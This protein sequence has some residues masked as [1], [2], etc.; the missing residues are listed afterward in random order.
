MTDKRSI[1]IFHSPDADDA[2][3]FYGMANGS[4]QNAQFN[5]LHE[6]SDIE[7]LNHR[8]L[9]GELEVSAVS[10]HAFAHLKDR[11]AIL[12]SGA[13]LGGIDY[14]PILVALEPLN[15][16]D[17]ETHVFAIPGELTSAALAFRMYLKENSVKAELVNINFDKVQEAIRDGAVEAGI[18]IHEGQL[19]HR[20]QGFV[21]I[22]DLGQWWW[23]QTGLP[24]PLGIN[25]IRK[26]LG[27]E[28]MQAAARVIK[29]SIEYGLA[30]RKEA[31]EYAL[32][33][34]RGISYQEADRFIAMYVNEHARDIGED[35]IKAITL[36]LERAA[37]HGLIPKQ[38]ALQFI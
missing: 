23:S 5:F 28:A 22:L 18:I 3:M 31:I 17:G 1:T 30:N 16:L 12:R 38:V 27:S 6:T 37:G 9:R 15:L 8:A 20:R 25:V 26:D 24:L 34:G 4:V 10:A 2:F 14:G 35:G 33:F 7:S 19:T 13:S 29:D 32:Q 21:S 11:Y 36:F